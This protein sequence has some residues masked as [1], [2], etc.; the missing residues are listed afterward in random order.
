MTQKKM[1]FYSLIFACLL[2]SQAALSA[3]LVKNKQWQNHQAIRVLFLDGDR[4]LHQKVIDIAPQ[5]LQGTGLSFRFYHDF[6]SAPSTTHIR[7]S[8]KQHNGSQLGDHGDY[9][10]RHPTMNLS[11]LAKEQLSDSG[12]QRLILHEFGH[13]LGLEHEYLNPYWPYDQSFLQD[14]LNNCYPKMQAIGYQSNEA[15]QHCQ[16]INQPLNK[17]ETLATAYDE[18][19][20][21]NYPIRWTD[22]DGIKRRIKASTQL[23][24]L[25]HYAMQLWYP[26]K[27]L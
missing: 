15:I 16:K 9:L 19:S 23:S 21:M 12:M 24:Y 10:S 18:A 1:T 11:Q 5:W 20:I 3:V 7:I 14:L 2:L 27:A 26:I 17:R 13:A 25:D 6:K 8:F 22:K 4:T